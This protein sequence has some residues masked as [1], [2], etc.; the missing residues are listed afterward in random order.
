MTSQRPS[1]A[2]IKNLTLL[3]STS[4]M[5]GTGDTACNSGSNSSSLKL[6]SPIYD[7]LVKKEK[8]NFRGNV[9]KNGCKKKTIFLKNIN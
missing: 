5:S 6:S 2:K 7:F 1:Q 3:L 4:S 9:Y 8:K